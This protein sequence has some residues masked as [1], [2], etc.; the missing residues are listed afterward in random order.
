MRKEIDSLV[1]SCET[2]IAISESKA[3]PISF[4]SEIFDK[5]YSELNTKLSAISDE[6]QINDP[7]K[8]KK[9]SEYNA[10][11]QEKDRILSAFEILADNEAMLDPSLAEKRRNFSKFSIGVHLTTAPKLEL[12][13]PQ[14]D[15]ARLNM[16]DIVRKRGQ[17]KINRRA[18]DER[19]PEEAL[20]L[21]MR[22][23]PKSARKPVNAPPINKPDPALTH[24]EDGPEQAAA[25]LSN[26]EQAAEIL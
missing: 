20:Q 15:K 4:W 12:F 16:L 19:R 10:V 14:E 11:V 22:D 18:E 3:N 21:N 6:K 1:L 13:S 26:F 23:K 2:K 24:K 25:Q 5:L 7:E 8:E 17:A 9:Q